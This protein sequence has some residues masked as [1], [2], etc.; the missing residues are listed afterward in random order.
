MSMKV[1]Y[2]A[3][4][5][6]KKLFNRE[7]EA[8]YKVIHDTEKV[9]LLHC[10]VLV[11]SAE[12]VVAETIGQAAAYFKKLQAW[13][14]EADVCVFESSYPSMGVG[15]EIAM[16]TQL[17]KSVIVLHLPGKRSDTLA[18]L[19]SD[20]LQV[21]EYTLESLKTVLAEALAYAVEQ[22]DTRFNF[23]VSPR[24]INYLDWV[25]KKK[26]IPRAVYLRRLIEE[27]LKKNRDYEG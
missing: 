9:T 26:R 27:D 1:F 21:I 16:A 4:L 13:V 20:K 2:N 7:Y 18:G 24:I 14:K 25:S 19:P 22:Q 12:K 3:S 5:T 11:G 6:G 15:Y 17:G 8:I 10:P 23:F